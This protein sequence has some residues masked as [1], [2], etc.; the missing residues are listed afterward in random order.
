M[1]VCVEGSARSLHSAGNVLFLD[2]G[3]SY[4]S[5]FTCENSSSRPL[6]MSAPFSVCVILKV[7]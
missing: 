7:I 5:V 4:T 6:K 2:M 1:C 3:T